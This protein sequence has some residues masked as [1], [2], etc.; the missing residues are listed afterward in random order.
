VPHL[1]QILSKK[2]RDKKN[3]VVQEQD[4]PGSESYRRSR[5]ELTTYAIIIIV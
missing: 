2:K 4:K 5:E 1:A 3:K